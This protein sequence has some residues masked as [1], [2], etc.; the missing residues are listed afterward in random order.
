VL[1]G[2]TRV[3]IPLRQAAARMGISYYGT[4]LIQP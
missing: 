2:K 4:N 1:D 3:Q